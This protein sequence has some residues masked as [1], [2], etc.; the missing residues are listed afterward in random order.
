MFLLLLEQWNA[1]SSGARSCLYIQY[2]T[3]QYILYGYIYT[4]TRNIT[5]SK[6]VYIS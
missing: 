4:Q 5:E 1:V 2:N 6:S 3:I